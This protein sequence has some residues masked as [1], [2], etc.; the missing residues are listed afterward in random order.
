MGKDL[1][2]LLY[3]DQDKC[4]N[5]HKCISVCPVKFCNDGSG[6]AVHINC[7]MCIAC[8]ACIDACSHQAR[9]YKDDM[10]A[11]VQTLQNKQKTVAIVA[12]AIASNFP[13]TYLKI[14]AFLK[15]LGIHA[16][17]DVSFGAELTIKSYVDYL[18]NEEPECIIAQPCPAIVSYIQIY[19]PELLQYL[20]PADS[21]MAHTMKMIRN[22]YS[23][24][25]NHK[26]AVISPCVAK[27]REFDEI[28]IG[29]FNITFQSLHHYFKANNIDLFDYADVAYDNPPAERAV[30]FST[31]GGLLRTAEREVSAIG[32][33]S[34]KIE[35]KEVVY[36]YFNALYND[37]KD[38]VSPVLIDCLNCHQGC[39]GG[40]GSIAKHQSTDRIEYA[41]E[42]RKNQAQK[43]YANKKDVDKALGKY[44]Q[45]EL[46]HRSYQ[47][48]S[49]NNLIKI[50][51]EQEFKNLYVKM[52][53]YTKT[54]MYNCAY[55][56]YNTCENMAIA[57]HNGLNRVENCYQFKS[58]IIEEIADKVKETTQ[59]L[60][61]KGE[62]IR[63]SAHQIN[64][65]GK[66][67]K[68]E[69]EL[70]LEVVNSSSNK[71]NDF[72]KIAGTISSISRKTNILALN[73][74]IE[75]ARVGQHGKGFDIVA[76]EVRKLAERSGEEAGKIKPYLDGIAGLFNE[77][78]SG[79]N[80]ASESY[81]NSNRL[82]GEINQNITQISEMILELNERVELFEEKAHEV[83][84][85]RR[86]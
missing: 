79:I 77:F 39:N 69:L 52:R 1:R 83:L 36:S 37:I 15:D 80:K 71:L 75:A 4:V 50:P 3:V 58:S 29:D 40:S 73:A 28:G 33:I 62:D 85:E 6:T 81:T 56:G 46:Y 35:G 42:R 61:K 7:N 66:K 47:N 19:R 5:C 30:L 55:C 25:K 13:N 27:R 57:I 12:P 14:N 16:I 9:Y 38:G 20:A 26:I 24:Y 49:G 32:K 76:G 78:I 64:T 22:Y 11:F 31:P 72:D 54:D 17:F 18:Q 10:E 2:A 65:L 70:L 23:Q 41:I 67:L 45:K 53:K 63:V 86:N 43:Q 8:G 82:N 68:Q 74:A 51:N 59:K 60:N 84:G 44:W 34:R 21:P 48:L